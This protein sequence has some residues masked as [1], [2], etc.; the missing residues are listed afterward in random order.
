M[1]TQTSPK[2]NILYYYRFMMY[3]N[4]TRRLPLVFAIP[5][6]RRRGFYC[7]AVI[8][9]PDKQVCF[10]FDF[11]FFFKHLY[12]GTTLPYHL[13]I[14]R[15]YFNLYSHNVIAQCLSHALNVLF[16]HRQRILTDLR[17]LQRT[18]DITSATSFYYTR[19]LRIYHQRDKLHH[20]QQILNSRIFFFGFKRDVSEILHTM[21]CKGMIMSCRR[22]SNRKTC[23]DSITI[24]RFSRI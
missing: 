15:M 19:T 24:T 5:S 12:H 6:P 10:V 1:F 9:G 7:R 16:L 18:F 14:V 17:R 13:R 3:V 22:G 4:R 8:N 11:F 20:H 2:Y 21:Y 23:V